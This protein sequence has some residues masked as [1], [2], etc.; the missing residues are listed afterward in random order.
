[1]GVTL[2]LGR[3]ERRSRGGSDDDGSGEARGVDSEDEGSESTARR[4]RRESTRDCRPDPIPPPPIPERAPIP[5]PNPAW[6]GAAA[7]M[8]DSAPP[9]GMEEADVAEANGR[10][11]VDEAEDDPMP[12]V[13]GRAPI[14]P[15]PRDLGANASAA[16]GST[17]GGDAVSPG[18]G[19]SCSSS[20]SSPYSS[21]SPSSSSS[22]STCTSESTSESSSI[23]TSS[24]SCCTPVP[25][26]SRGRVVERLSRML[27]EALAPAET[28]D[29]PL[30][31]P[32]QLPVPHMLVDAT[33]LR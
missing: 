25:P 10:R 20:Y 29:C 32:Y 23:G 8:G 17:G 12:A 30:L 19:A 18:T 9:S 13:A 6:A 22:A 24:S 26:A 11:G 4:C 14:P 33:Y 27:G 16:L 15:F 21:S 1:M 3:K 7:D 28:N 2:A 5:A 31:A